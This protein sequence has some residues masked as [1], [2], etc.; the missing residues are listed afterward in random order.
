M[1][2]GS[3]IWK[4]GIAA[5]VL[6]CTLSASGLTAAQDAD[7]SASV[8]DILREG[9]AAQARGDGE[10]LLT[11]ALALA[12]SGAR[13]DTGDAD[14]VRVWIRDAQ[15]MGAKLPKTF[16]A[17]RGLLLGPAYKSGKIAANGKFTT[18][19]SFAGGQ[20]A[21]I[22]VVPAPGAALSLRV[23]DDE[24]DEVCA[25]ASSSENLGCRWVPV[26]TAPSAITVVNA[27]RK[28]AKFYLVMN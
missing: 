25:V 15:T 28:P 26:Y 11:A 23:V 10:A 2:R 20:M 4:R 16:Y 22:L 7:L 13:P 24:G 9:L 18:R 5:L 14:L 1:S 3:R 17:S 21:D 8:G 12:R 27:S 6:S 19:Q